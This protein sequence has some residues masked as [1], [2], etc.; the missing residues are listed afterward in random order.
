[1]IQYYKFAFD[2]ESDS[3]SFVKENNS[4][5]LDLPCMFIEVNISHNSTSNKTSSNLTL[6]S[7][8]I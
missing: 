2:I 1:M 7:Q 5:Q 6:L 3:M 8:S 4:L